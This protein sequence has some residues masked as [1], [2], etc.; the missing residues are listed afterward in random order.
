MVLIDWRGRERG[1]SSPTYKLALAA[2]SVCE[3]SQPLTKERATDRKKG[4]EQ[5]GEKGDTGKSRGEMETR[6]DHLAPKLSAPSF[7]SVK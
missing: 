2:A 1:A 6:R 5:W 4:E 7:S 3:E